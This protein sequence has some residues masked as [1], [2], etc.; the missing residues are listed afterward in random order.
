M[1]A[2]TGSAITVPAAST[3]TRMPIS[4][5]SFPHAND[6]AHPLV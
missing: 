1:L 3:G 4:A 2:T 6:G 5:E